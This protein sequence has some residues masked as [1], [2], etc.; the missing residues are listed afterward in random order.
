MES[1]N[2]TFAP[3]Q[4]LFDERTAALLGVEPDVLA[5][6]PELWTRLIH[7]D[8]LPALKAAGQQALAAPDAL[9]ARFRVL[10]PNGMI[11]H[12]EVHAEVEQTSKG[13][14]H[15]LLGVAWDVTPWVESERRLQLQS[16]A[17]AAAANGI[18]ITDRTGAIEWVNPAFTALT[19]YDAAESYGKNP[20]DL[21]RSGLHPDT[22]YQALWATILA[23][24]VW[25]G[26]LTN[27]R[28][29]GVVYVEEQTITPVSGA[30][31]E[32]THFIGIKQDVTAR[33]A[34]EAALRESESRYRSLFENNHSVMLLIDPDTCTVVDANAA[35]VDYYGW[36]RSQLQGKPIEEINTLPPAEARA[37]MKL[38]AN[39]QRGQFYFRH[40]RRWFVARG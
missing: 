6:D 24:R 8:D 2:S 29:D 32:I 27:R 36:T 19:G 10:L 30:H 13:P 34:A 11:R 7:P 25:R 26:E 1:G 35:A 37:E 40:R 38:A 15:R 31:G 22:Y 3:K 12:L 18:V 21:V 28:K 17:L 5:R 9:H 16:T 39:E 33:K 20:R 23:G 14:P 4:P